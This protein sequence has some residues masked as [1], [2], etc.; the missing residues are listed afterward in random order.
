AQHDQ[1]QISAKLACGAH[2]SDPKRLKAFQA[3]VNFTIVQG[4]LEGGRKL[5]SN[6]GGRED[7][8]GTISSNLVL[9]SGTGSFASG[10]AWIYQFSGT[11]RRIG[12]TVLS[13]RQESTLGAV[14][15]RE[16]TLR[17]LRNWP[18]I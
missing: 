15:G 4:R 2:S 10:A 16:C 14:G 1:T 3:L 13:G 12:E 11:R 18:A 5:I 17:F 7:F 9:V 8:Q 6:G